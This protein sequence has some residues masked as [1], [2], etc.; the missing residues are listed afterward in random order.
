LQQEFPRPNGYTPL[1]EALTALFEVVKALPP[2]T[3]ITIIHS[4]DGQP[5][6]PVSLDKYPKAAKFV[7]DR[8]AAVMRAASADEQQAKVDELHRQ[9]DDPETVDGKRLHRLLFDEQFAESKRLMASLRDR[10]V[11]FVSVDFNGVDTLKQ[12][13]DAA[14]GA[15]DDYLLVRPASRLIEILHERGL[16]KYN[17]VL[18]SKP[19]TPIAAS[20]R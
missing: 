19:A 13:H 15:P 16:T 12:L 1:V 20:A 6:S 14:G 5:S 8:I 3:R 7:A 9:L 17:G 11:R 18:V 10:N 4:G 2:G